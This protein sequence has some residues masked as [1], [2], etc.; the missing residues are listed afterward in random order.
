MQHSESSNFRN[1]APKV[2]FQPSK[3]TIMGSENAATPYINSTGIAENTFDAIVIGSG[4]S[5][6]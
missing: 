3:Y 5:G 4:I 2:Y 6:G 1:V